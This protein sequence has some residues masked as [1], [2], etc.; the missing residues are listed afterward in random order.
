MLGRL[1]Q[2]LFQRGLMFH[3][4]VLILIPLCVLFV[5]MGWR[6][7]NIVPSNGGM[8]ELPNGAWFLESKREWGGRGV[9][10]KNTD[11]TTKDVVLPCVTH[12]LVVLS[13][14][15]YTSDPNVE[16]TR[17]R[18]YPPLATMGSTLAESIKAISGRFTNTAYGIFSGKR[19]AYPVVANYKEDIGNVSVW[20]KIHGVPVTAFS[21]DG[22]SDIAFKLGTPLILDSY[23]FDMCIQSWG[24]LSYA[25]ALIEVRA[26][27]ELRDNIVVVF[28]HVHAECPKNTESDVVKNM[29]KHGQ[30]PRGV[31]LIL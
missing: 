31:P 15:V 22:L 10:E 5:I 9:K 24:R 28:G 2:I 6:R 29:K 13:S 19:V 17:P 21:D 16:N 12:E 30:A 11:V 7:Q 23:T 20:V 4:E 26:D 18:L 27:V 1:R 8:C 25:R 14:L 3:A